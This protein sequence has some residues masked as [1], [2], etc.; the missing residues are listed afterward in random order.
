MPRPLRDHSDDRAKRDGIAFLAPL[1]GLVLLMPPILNLFTVNRLLFGVPLEA[2]Y[3]FVVWMSLI[4][5]AVILSRRGQ[6]REEESSST[7]GSSPPDY[8]GQSGLI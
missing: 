6:F 7:E 3:L 5:G 4:L 1:F 2:I 8:P